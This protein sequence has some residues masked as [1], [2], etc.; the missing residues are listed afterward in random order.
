MKTDTETLIAAMRILAQ[1]IKS[2]DG[3]ANAVTAEAAD[4]IME[5]HVELELWKAEAERWRDM[6][7]EY[8]EILEGQVQETVERLN[9]IWEDL[10]ELKRKVEN[11]MLDN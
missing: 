3:I 6:Y 7:I 1:D 5:L 2:E 4:R 11:D 10:D 8:D 9:K